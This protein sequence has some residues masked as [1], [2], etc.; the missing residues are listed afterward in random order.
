MKAINGIHYIAMCIIVLTYS[1]YDTLFYHDLLTNV[2]RN[3]IWYL[4]KDVSYILFAVGL[5]YKPQMMKIGLDKFTSVSVYAFIIV[6]GFKMFA[7][8][9]FNSTDYNEYREFVNN[10]I[11]FYLQWTTFILLMITGSIKWQR[12]SG[13]GRY[14]SG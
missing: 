9:G 3:R 7:H 1:V 12:S 8:I 11:V 6:I 13:H 4:G 5:I 14:T 10:K 2:I